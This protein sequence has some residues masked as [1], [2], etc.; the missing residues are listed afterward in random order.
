MRGFR[1]LTAG[2][3]RALP[4]ATRRAFPAVAS[5][6]LSAVALAG[7]SLVATPVEPAFGAD[8]E[9]RLSG[10]VRTPERPAPR[11]L[12]V[13]R[14]DGVDY[15]DVNDIARLVRATK[16]WRS[17]L[18]KMVLRVNDRRVRLTV[19]SP[20]VYVDDE[21]RNLMVPV[22]WHAGRI[23]APVRLV[24]DVLD[25]LIPESVAWDRKTLSLRLVSGDPNILGVRYDVRKNG[26]VVEIRLSEPLGGELEFPRPDRIVVRIPGGVLTQAVDADLSGRGL[27]DS[28][29][30]EQEPQEATLTF[31]LGPL[32]GTAELLPRTSPPRLLLAI[33]EGLPEDI[34]L[35]EF[36]R[37]SGEGTLRRPL[38]RIVV[39]PGHGGSDPGTVSSNGV[40]EKDITLAIAKDL[41]TILQSEGD[42]DVQLT[43]S[44][45]RF[46]AAEQRVAKANQADADLYLSIHA[47][48]WFH[49]DMQGLSVGVARPS[50]SEDGGLADWG[51]TPPGTHRNATRFAEILLEYLAEG[52]PL[53]SRGLRTADYTELY[54][55]RMPGVHVEC[56][57]LTNP[58]EARFLSGWSLSA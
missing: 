33:S 37:S 6:A 32:G 50:I 18:E 36:E 39:D 20:F 27:I 43:R 31:H 44:D 16:Y 1:A 41:A 34:P 22:R 17:E 48:G 11:A 21:G 46:L 28:L 23:V 55:L 54:G 8:E 7:I 52:L 3:L 13:Y 40:S 30:T 24:T 12:A 49:E 9:T 10:V 58:E 26:T 14:F 51:T 19:G 38:R 56:G 47:D 35:P 42:W 57:F 4:S 5:R 15:L 45:D 2:A 25:P 53:A 29:V